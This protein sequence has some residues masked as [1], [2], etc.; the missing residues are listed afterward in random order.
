MAIHRFHSGLLAFLLVG[1]ASAPKT[2]QPS[3]LQFE[4]ATEPGWA[5]PFALQASA[6]GS[7]QL[8]IGSSYKEQ[9][10]MQT[11]VSSDA[12]RTFSSSQRSPALFPGG[13]HNGDIQLLFGANRAVLV[14]D[15]DQEQ[16]RLNSFTSSDGEHWEKG[17][18]LAIHP[19]PQVTPVAHY[20]AG[21]KTF[22]LVGR[23]EGLDYPL[24]VSENEGQDWELKTVSLPNP[25]G[26]S[27]IT[28]T[29]PGVWDAPEVAVDTRDRIHWFFPEYKFSDASGKQVKGSLYLSLDAQGQTSHAQVEPGQ[30]NSRSGALGE[31]RSLPDHLY[32]VICTEAESKETNR[33][34]IPYRLDFSQ[35]QDGGASWSPA[36]VLDEHNGMKQIV[37]VAGDGKLIVVAWRDDR[38]SQPGLYCSGSVDGGGHWSE[39]QRVGELPAGFHLLVHQGEILLAGWR[40]GPSWYQPGPAFCIRGKVGR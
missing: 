11:S 17:G 33:I 30:Y 37:R 12:G 25:E 4:S 32:R 8:M 6:D 29:P 28:V 5:A 31:N 10:V 16:P 27:K 35:S 38:S 19:V 21:N 1:C 3:R 14:G 2:H 22:A 13:M 24:Y 34:S 9:G 7:H 18:S 36:C 26:Y 40:Q 20:D 15:G 23:S 39:A